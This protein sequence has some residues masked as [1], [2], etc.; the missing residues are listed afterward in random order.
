MPTRTRSAARLARRP[1]AAPPRAQG[2][3]A[4][5]A[6]RRPRAPRVAEIGQ[7]AVAHV[8]GDEAA[9]AGDRRPRRGGGRHRS[10]RACPPGRAA[11]QSAVEPTRSTNITVSCRRSAWV[12]G[13]AAGLGVASASAPRGGGGPPSERRVSMASSSLRLWPMTVTPMSLRSSAVSLGRTAASISLSRNA[14][15]YC[16]KPS[17]RSQA[18][19]STSTPR[20]P[21]R[22]HCRCPG[23]RHRQWL[24][25]R[26][27]ASC[28]RRP[29][30]RLIDCMPSMDASNCIRPGICRRRRRH[31][32][33]SVAA[34]S[35]PNHG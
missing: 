33:S 11:R 2:R 29:S 12:A 26:H 5:P 32:M 27:G 10:S 28:G 17:P 21:T 24:H 23:L 8:L 4:P 31:T 13:A 15:S 34:A 3:R 18:P 35:P 9:E 16:P 25:D 6:R 22:R 14:C 1:R 20:R 7:H 30:P 19:T